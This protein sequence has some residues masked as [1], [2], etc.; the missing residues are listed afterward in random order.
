MAKVQKRGPPRTGCL[1]T[2]RACKVIPGAKKI[3]FSWNQPF[4]E[5][6][7]S[8]TGRTKCPPPQTFKWTA[9]VFLAELGPP[10]FS[11]EA[12]LRSAIENTPV[13]WKGQVLTHMHVQGCITKLLELFKPTIP[14]RKVQTRPSGLEPTLE[15]HTAALLIPPLTNQNPYPIFGIWKYFLLPGK[16]PSFPEFQAVC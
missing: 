5:R 1:A 2:G 10:N 14:S 13:R 12:S 11:Y 4:H 8:M 15:T 3:W 6:Q 16:F 9:P 7:L